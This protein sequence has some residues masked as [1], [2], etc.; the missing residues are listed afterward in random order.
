MEYY[1]T[2]RLAEFLKQQHD[3]S[4]NQALSPVAEQ[5]LDRWV[6]GRL[7]IW[8]WLWRDGVQAGFRHQL[9]TNA[10]A[11]AMALASGPLFGES[12]PNA[13]G[14]HAVASISALFWTL[15]TLQR[16]YAH[17]SAPRSYRDA[18]TWEPFDAGAAFAPIFTPWFAFDTNRRPTVPPTTLD[19]LYF[20][21]TKYIAFARD[22]LET[23]GGAID[24]SEI[25][26]SSPLPDML[27]GPEARPVWLGQATAMYFQLVGGNKDVFKMVMKATFGTSMTPE[28][29]RA[30]DG[31]FRTDLALEFQNDTTPRPE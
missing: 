28:L 24:L 19:D 31:A 10:A 12:S 22:L 7:N 15:D 9:Y 4:K 26:L 27:R 30:L 6:R 11:A 2:Y 23:G 25:A 5:W 14:L 3:P 16:S 17:T 20:I 1:M 13:A 8:R 29:A 21:T 18:T